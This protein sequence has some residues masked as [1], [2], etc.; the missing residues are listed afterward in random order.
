MKFWAIKRQGHGA[1][2]YY[3]GDLII[4]SD[5]WTSNPKLASRFKDDRDAS[6]MMGCMPNGYAYKL[7]QQE[8][9]II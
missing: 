3:A 7:V 8:Q 2:E 6:T 5:K 9:A 4:C 1:T